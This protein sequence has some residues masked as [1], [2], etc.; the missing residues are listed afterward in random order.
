MTENNSININ[1]IN[2]DNNIAF[3]KAETI[4][5]NKNIIPLFNSSIVLKKISESNKNLSLQSSDDT[6]ILNMIPLNNKLSKINN[7]LKKIH[8]NSTNSIVLQDKANKFYYFFNTLIKK[9]ELY[10][11]RL[12]F[13]NLVYRLNNLINIFYIFNNIKEL[14]AFTNRKLISNIKENLNIVPKNFILDKKTLFFPKHLIKISYNRSNNS[15]NQNNFNTSLLNRSI[16]DNILPLNN[17]HALTNFNYKFIYKNNEYLNLILLQQKYLTENTVETTNKNNLLELQEQYSKDKKYQLLLDKN[18]LNY[19]LNKL[20]EINIYVE[21]LIEKLNRL[22]DVFKVKKIN[23]ALNNL[24]NTEV[25][26][27]NKDSI[28]NNNILFKFTDIKKFSLIEFYELFNKYSNFIEEGQNESKDNYIFNL[29]PYIYNINSDSKTNLYTFFSKDNYN[30]IT[31]VNSN[32]LNL[33]SN[34]LP[35]KE[36]KIKI[37]ETMKSILNKYNIA[38]SNEWILKNTLLNSKNQYKSDIDQLELSGKINKLSFNTENILNISRKDYIKNMVNYLITQKDIKSSDF[39]LNNSINF[40]WIKDSI[41]HFY[42]NSDL[43]KTNNNNLN[44]FKGL[45]ANS[46]VKIN[47]YPNLKFDQFAKGFILQKLLNTNSNINGSVDTQSIIE[48]TKSEYMNWID[49]NKRPVINQYLKAMSV[50]NNRK[51]GTF[52]YFTNIFSYNFIN[53]NNKMIKNIYKLLKLVFKSM[54]SLISKPVYF[55]SPNKIIIHLFYFL[56]IPNIKGIKKRLKYNNNILKGINSDNNL[57][58]DLNKDNNKLVLPI[59]KKYFYKLINGVHTKNDNKFNTILT[60]NNNTIMNFINLNIP[61]LANKIINIKNNF[62]SINKIK[63]IIIKINLISK[64]ILKNYS[65]INDL[66]I[67]MNLRLKLVE[68]Y[69]IKNRLFLIFSLPE[70]SKNNTELVYSNNNFNTICISMYSKFYNLNTSENPYLNNNSILNNKRYNIYFK[71]YIDSKLNLIKIFKEMINNNPNLFKNSSD[72]EGNYLI[73]NLLAYASE[74]D[75]SKLNISVLNSNIKTLNNK[76]NNI[77]LLNFKNKV[78]KN[79]RINNLKKISKLRNKF[80]NFN[81]KKRIKLI[82]LYNISLINLYPNRFESLCNIL[83]YC[84]KKN[85]VLDLTR[86]H[87]PYNDANI[88]VNMLA[89]MIRK[90][91]FSRITRKLFSNTIIKNVNNIFYFKNVNLLPAFLTGLKIKLGGKVL[92]IKSKSRDTVKIEEIGASS[93]GKINYKDFARYT[94]KHKRGAYSIS[95][96]SGQ[97]FY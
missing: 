59:A 79:N 72:K 40:N 51:K 68:L 97:N 53:N 60:N 87:Y 90:I 39:V 63:N 30:Y 42:K 24:K 33:N 37:E 25:L 58:F 5:F 86:I 4:S 78:K 21:F 8:L 36:N 88:L 41:N 89:I 43:A 70:F 52:I 85:V 92:N 20:N 81:L 93:P 77:A 69:R 1:N 15:N 76:N 29:I 11:L 9:N 2:K 48:E 7:S 12:E 19:L 31:S 84:F 95:V 17:R 10:S 61:V 49:T 28:N 55:I 66:E 73:N 26:A 71:N 94:S 57:N 3:Y 62:N 96:S 23:S 75:L 91:S 67:K 80:N 65:K 34:I 35:S 6:L 38:S 82:K 83:N 45:D 18:E 50:F 27:I 64:L 54:Y 47:Y 44:L 74:N 56:L 22:N 32:K 13:N 16:F 14:N 46:P